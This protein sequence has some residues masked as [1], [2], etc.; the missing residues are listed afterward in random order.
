MSLSLK[1]KESDLNDRNIIVIDE[2]NIETTYKKIGFGIESDVYN[3]NNKYAIKIFYDA[4]YGTSKK[5]ELNKK[6]KK[7]ERLMKLNDPSFCFPIDI[8]TDSSLN[9]IGYYMELLALKQS[10]VMDFDQLQT[11]YQKAIDKTEIFS[12][13][14]RTD[15]AMKRIH[16][17]DIIIGDIHGHNILIDQNNNP[18]FIDT[19]NYIYKN[20]NFDILP[21]RPELYVENY[22][23]TN[24]LK[25]VDIF[26]YSLLVLE[27]ITGY[28]PMYYEINLNNYLEKVMK[29]LNLNN[30]IK[31]GLKCI[32]SDSYN[33]PYISDVISEVNPNE[34][35]YQKTII[36]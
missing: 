3:Y 18:R 1:I 31:D 33:K 27:F 24:R 15:K 6:M 22:G 21:W 23:K 9:K 26:F 36:K 8:V 35:I 12:I 14:M 34:K 2:N 17:K 4:F 5:R 28:Q 29:E 19:D 30:H 20:F 32:F 7:V 13:L 10:E 25:D 16:K 11:E